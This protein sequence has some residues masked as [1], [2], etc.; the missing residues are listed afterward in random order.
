MQIG[1]ASAIDNM[2]AAAEGGSTLLFA[3]DRHLGKSSMLL[4]VTERILRDGEDRIAL[5]VDLR[6]G[7]TDS[8]V[9]AATLL[10]QAGKQGAGAKVKAMTAKGLLKKTL[11]PGAVAGVRAAGVLLGEQDDAAAV[12]K[13][14]DLL[15]P[16]GSSLRGALLALDA[17]GRAAG[18]RTVIVLDEAQ[19]LV[20]WSDAH[21]VQQEIATAIKRPGSTVN[22]VFSGSE[23]STL[24][25]LYED[26]KAPLHG[27]GRGFPL[28]EISHDDWYS[29]LR[30]RFEHC[31]VAIERNSLHQIVYHSKGHPLRTML[32][33]AHTLDWLFDDTVSADTVERA[34][35]D[36]ERH[37]SWSLP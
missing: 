34:L 35:K 21:Q 6:D 2:T 19:D 15:A 8:G 26:A 5:S 25:A 3:E 36:A 32:I 24:L 29:G 27:L 9:L 22:F 14:M 13:L 17:N 12:G 23:K 28:P 4:A 30:E 11:A 33:C 16:K 1:R 37:P 20:R 10:A 18:E 7:I 31:G